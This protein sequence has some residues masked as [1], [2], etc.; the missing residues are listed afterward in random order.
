M[1]KEKAQECQKK[2][3]SDIN[4]FNL[5]DLLQSYGED[6]SSMFSVKAVWRGPTEIGDL[7]APRPGVSPDEVRKIRSFRDLSLHLSLF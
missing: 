1:G 7:F 3:D 5:S 4:S 2:Y 6:L